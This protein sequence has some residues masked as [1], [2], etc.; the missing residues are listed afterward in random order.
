M[1]RLDTSRTFDG[2][3]TRWPVADI[4]SDH[5]SVPDDGSDASLTAN[6]GL[7]LLR[8]LTTFEQLWYTSP[9]DDVR[10]RRSELPSAVPFLLLGANQGHRNNAS[11]RTPL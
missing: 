9:S 7:G 1:D 5:L 3:S 10:T 6:T 2:F 4:G 11:P 8:G